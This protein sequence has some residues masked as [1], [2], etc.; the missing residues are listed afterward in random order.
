MNH[1]ETPKSQNK[2]SQTQERDIF[3]RDRSGDLVRRSDPGFSRIEEVIRGATKITSKLNSSYHDEDEIRDIFSE[4]TGS[5]VDSSFYLIPP[6]YTDFGRNIKI[7]KNVFINHACTFMD[8]GGI[9]L[10]DDV[11]IGPKVNLVT[12]NHPVDPSDRKA[13]VSK[14]IWIKRNVWVGVGATVLPGVTIGENSIVGAAAVVT[15]D[16]PPNTIVAGIPAKIVR[17]LK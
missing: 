17:T 9:T 6:F 2:A 14:P 7:G 8:R 4:L 13:T 5:K 10:E 16:V 3:E 1:T 15:H 12:T 11:K